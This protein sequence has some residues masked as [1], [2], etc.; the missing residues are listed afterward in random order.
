MLGTYVVVIHLKS[1]AVSIFLLR[2]EGEAGPTGARVGKCPVVCSDSA[3]FTLCLL[4]YAIKFF[5]VCAFLLQCCMVL[6]HCHI[7]P[8]P[9]Q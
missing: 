1:L 3:V 7:T 6:N 4:L 5:L 2:K 9:T 8:L